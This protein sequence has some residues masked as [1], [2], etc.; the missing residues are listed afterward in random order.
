M[1]LTEL[2]VLVLKKLLQQKAATIMDACMAEWEWTVWIIFSGYK[3]SNLSV[4]NTVHVSDLLLRMQVNV[5][6]TMFRE[7]SLSKQEA[8]TIEMIHT[9][10][11]PAL[12]W[13]SSRKRVLGVREATNSM[14]W[15]LEKQYNWQSID[16][17]S[18]IIY[19]ILFQH[20]C[21]LLTNHQKKIDEWM[22]PHPPYVPL[23]L[24]ACF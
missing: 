16:W 17:L 23:S 15:K 5:Q 2:C 9:P 3:D 13:W 22:D 4:Y 8:R 21:L 14:L 24:H 1:I 11:P 7:E 19:T 12:L 18:F 10:P 6:E 20:A